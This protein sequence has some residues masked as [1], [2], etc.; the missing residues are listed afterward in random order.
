M[1]QKKKVCIKARLVGKNTDGVYKHY[2]FIDLDRL[3]YV[4]CTR[5]PNWQGA[6]VE[7]GEDGFLE[8]HSVIGGQDRYYDA[9]KD[10]YCHYQQDATYFLNFVPIT[11]VLSDGY[12]VEKH[13]L[14]IG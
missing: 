7:I 1:E 3:D 6:D 5:V 4:M 10:H 14:V 11:K 12:V 2:V 8:Y 13:N 9:V